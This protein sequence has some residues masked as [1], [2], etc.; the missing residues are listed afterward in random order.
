MKATAAALALL[1]PVIVL[2]APDEKVLDDFEDPSAWSVT[3]SDDVKAAIRPAAGAGGR[4]MCL[5]F[6]FGRVSGYA[7]ARR[8]IALAYPGNYEFTF[9]LRGDA[10]PNTLEFKLVDASGENVWWARRPDFIFPRE[11]QPTRFRKRHIEFAWGPTADR[12][13]VRSAAIELVVS[14]SR[15]GKG[16]VCF[17]RLALRE[18]PAPREGH[19][20]IVA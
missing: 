12:T 2:A 5:D 4:A 9:D 1:V 13:L 18:L 11:W 10:P 15:G 7:V 8:E 14:S 3:S 19:A 16:G 6:D 20:T 17:A